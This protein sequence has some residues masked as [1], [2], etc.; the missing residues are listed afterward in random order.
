MTGRSIAYLRRSSDQQG[1]SLSA[2]LDWAHEEAVRRGLTL[3]GSPADLESALL[4]RDARFGD[5]CLDNAIT[6]SELDR[7]GLSALKRAVQESGVTHLLVH[8]RDRLARPDDPIDGVQLENELRP[9]G[10]TLVFSNETLL[11]R[12]GEGAEDRRLVE[13]ITSI[14]GYHESGKFLRDLAER[15]I[16][17]KQQLARDGFSTGGRAPYGFGRFLVRKLDNEIIRKLEDGERVRMAGCH[18]RHLP[19]NEEKLT[20]WLWMLEMKEAGWGIK[21]I[22][23]RLNELNIPSPDAGRTRTDQGETHLVSGRWSPTAVSSLCRNPL[24]IGIREYGRRSEGKHRRTS[25]NGCRHLTASDRNENGAV[26]IVRN[27]DSD[28]TQAAAGFE[29]EFERDRW[30]TIQQQM[31]ERST[32]QRGIRRAK[33]P[34]KYPLAT[35]VVDLTEGCGS[36]MYGT[37]HSGKSVYKCGRYQKSSGSD[38]FHNSVDAEA[39]L[40]VV[41]QTLRRPFVTGNLRDIVANRLRQRLATPHA[42][43][44]APNRVE[45]LQKQLETARRN[46]GRVEERWAVEEDDARHAAFGRQFDRLTAE[47]KELEAEIQIAERVL[48]PADD[49]SDPERLVGSALAI[50]DRLE[51]LANESSLRPQIGQLME[52][53][54]VW[55]G[56]DFIG[57]QKGKRTLRKLR[58]GTISVGGYHLSV[59]LHGKESL[60]SQKSGDNSV[61][62]PDDV[63]AACGSIQ[64]GLDCSSSDDNPAPGPVGPRRTESFTKVNRDDRI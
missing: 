41:L 61:V 17:A 32:N 57:V 4:S 31:D 23:N 55:V 50:L 9:P 3:T 33:D 51:D 29:A 8:K 2:Q 56:L 21:R 5:V 34:G 10:L 7:P 54:E 46:L 47:V 48:S 28:M 15:I 6:G 64:D 25:Q 24:I 27:P 38:C 60:R 59:P 58:G 11:P 40:A 63:Y 39:L 52:Q 19:D 44:D 30:Q 22:A 14:V 35:R 13:Q 53:L 42:G 16:A 37:P 1:L 43:S 18:V 36:I 49:T 26:H 20:N 12:H 45:I 62:E